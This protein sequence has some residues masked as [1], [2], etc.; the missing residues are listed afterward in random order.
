MEMNVKMNVIKRNGKE[1]PFDITKIVNAIGK[2]NNEVDH[3]HQMNDYQIRAVADNIAHKIAGYSH[4]ANVEDIQDMVETGI[5]EMRGY[6]VA[7]K[8]VRYRYKR[9]IS[10]K[11]NTTDDG[12]LSREHQSDTRFH[13]FFRKQ[14]VAVI[15][16]SRDRIE[17]HGSTGNRS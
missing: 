10:R 11:S 15:L 7:Q 14:A 17:F 16:S 9:E 5:M 13:L 2:A 8:Y 1:V 3:V 4:A 6:E 12:I